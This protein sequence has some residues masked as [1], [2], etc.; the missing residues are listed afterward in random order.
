MLTP[1]PLKVT[2]SMLLTDW[3]IR[4]AHPIILSGKKWILAK[5]TY[6]GPRE[7]MKKA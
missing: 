1:D 6:C 3:V 7:W 5:L 2:I 4:P